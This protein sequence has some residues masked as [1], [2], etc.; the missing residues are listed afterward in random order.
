MTNSTFKK[1]PENQHL[2]I[3]KAENTYVNSV[4]GELKPV[5]RSVEIYA[6]GGTLFYD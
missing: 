3:K 5:I 6:E 1:I 2:Q 4:T